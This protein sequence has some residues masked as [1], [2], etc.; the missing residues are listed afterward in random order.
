[1]RGRFPEPLAPHAAPVEPI[2]DLVD[3]LALRLGQVEEEERGE[4]R[5]R[6]HEGHEGV[7]TLGGTI[8]M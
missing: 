3:R 6:H 4:E 7:V 2:D 1:M 5:R 8:H